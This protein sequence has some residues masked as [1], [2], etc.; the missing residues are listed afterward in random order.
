VLAGLSSDHPSTS[1]L[2][3][4]LQEAT[5]ALDFANVERRVVPFAGLPMRSLLVHRNGAFVQSTSPRWARA[6][7]DADAKAQGSFVQTLR[8]IAEADLNVQ[9]AARLLRKHPNTVY[10]R[11]ERIRA[12]T[13]LDG[14]RYH[15]LTELLLA[16]DCRRPTATRLGAGRNVA[17]GE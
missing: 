6:F 2:P 8:A 15:D 9:K 16:S 14:Q 3:K 13:G 4:A 5:I 7:F 12:L 10:A 17:V 11:I 1:F